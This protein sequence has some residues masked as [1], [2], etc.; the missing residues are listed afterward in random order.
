MVI[1]AKKIL[2]NLKTMIYKSL[3]TK[4]KTLSKNYLRI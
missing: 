4:I 3:N 1:I 2:S